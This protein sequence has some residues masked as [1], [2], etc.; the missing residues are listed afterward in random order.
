MP[1]LF[2]PGVIRRAGEIDVVKTAGG[3]DASD[4]VDY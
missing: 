2:G 4:H 1:D 3:R